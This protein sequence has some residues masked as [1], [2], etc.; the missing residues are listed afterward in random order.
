MAKKKKIPRKKKSLGKKKLKK[1]KGKVKR[2]KGKKTKKSKK[3]KYQRGG[4]G[5]AIFALFDKVGVDK[6]TFERALKVAKAAKPD[7]T[8]GKAYFSWH[9][10]H[11]RNERDI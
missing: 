6:V 2:V 11:Y 10:N 1:V 7:T 3:T 8:Y 4:L 9:K 5:K